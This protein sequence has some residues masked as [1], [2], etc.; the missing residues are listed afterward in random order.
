MAARALVAVAAHERV[1]AGGQRD[2]HARAAHERRRC[3]DGGDH[4]DRGRGQHPLG[5]AGGLDQRQRRDRAGVLLL[6]AGQR[7]GQARRGVDDVGVGEQQPLARARARR[8][9]AAP[10]ACRPSPAA[11]AHRG[12]RRARGS[13]AAA[14]RI[15][16]HVPS[17]LSSSTTT[18]CRSG[19][20]SA[21]SERTAAPTPASSSRA[22][23]TTVTDGVAPVA[24]P[25]RADGR[26]AER[27]GPTGGRGPRPR[28]SR[29]RGGAEV[30][31]GWPDAT[32]RS[33]PHLHPPRRPR[34]ARR[35]GGSRARGAGGLPL[36]ER[37]LRRVRRGAR[38]RP[39]QARADRALRRRRRP[40]LAR[41]AARLLGRRALAGAGAGI[42][43]RA[44]RLGVTQVATD[45]AADPDYVAVPT[46]SRPGRRA[47]PADRGPRPARRRARRHPAAGVAARRA[48]G[49]RRRPGREL[50]QA[51]PARPQ[52]ERPQRAVA[53]LR[54]ARLRPRR[55]RCWS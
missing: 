2:R 3:D 34:A 35:P 10:T 51:L 31:V 9:A 30:P 19:Q 54:A 39:R 47:V 23:T 43:G 33:W 48:G 38:P 37:A 52:G 36:D 49:C 29:R 22:G 28:P 20:S 5:P 8:P 21:S 17:R 55:A 50:R 4:E 12:R 25:G 14:S 27:R 11:A 44:L 13:P 24:P 45:P 26:A 16:C 41:G 18:T 42:F 6:G 15:A 32:V 7:G 1:A 40:G 53:L 46:A